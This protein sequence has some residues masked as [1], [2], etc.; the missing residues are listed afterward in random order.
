MVR[1]T[2]LAK[3]MT[4][5]GVS[6]PDFRVWRERNASFERMAAFSTTSYNISGDEE[7]ERV[8]GAVASIELIP[9]LG[10]LPAQGRSFAAEEGQFGG[11]RVVI[12]SDNLWQRRFGANARLGAQTIKL[13]GEVYQVVGVMPPGFEFPEKNVSLWVPLALP[14]KSPYA[15]RGNYWLSAIG[16]L[17]PG[18][19]AAQAQADLDRIHR[20][21]EQEVPD[22]IGWG[23]RI[24]SLREATVG[25]VR[26][27]L[28]TLFAA[29]GFVLLIACANVANL[30]LAR[31]AARQKEIAIRTALGAGRLRLVRQLFTESLLMGLFGGAGGL[32]LA[33]WGIDA[34][35]GLGPNFPRAGEIKID[36]QVL[37]FTLLLTFVTS[38]L[39]GLVPALQISK[40]GLHEALKESARGTVG[41]ARRSRVRGAL[42][43]AEIALSMVLLVGAG[44]MLGSLYQLQ[45]VDPGFKTENILTVQLSLPKTKYPND[46]PELTANFFS[47]L[48]ERVGATPGAKAVGYSTSLPFTESSWGKLLTIE[49]RP[50]PK[51]MEEM[52]NVQYSQTNVDYYQTLGIPLLKGR[53]F[54]RT[55]TA[56]TQPVALINETMARRYWPDGDPL[57]Q[58]IFLGP[59]EEMVPAG[60]LPPGYRFIRWTIVGVI[61]DQ[62]KRGLDQPVGPEVFTLQ[63]QGL[64]ND[65]PARNMYFAIHTSIPPTNLA[66]AVRHQVQ[67]LDKEQPIAAVATM[68][69]LISDSLAQSRFG[70]ITL[71]AFAA[72]A[73][74]LAMAGIYGVMS[75][76][77]TQ[78]THE[79]GIRMALGARQSDVL[80]DVLREGMRLALAG[81][82]CGLVLALALTRLLGSLLYGV[83]AADPVVYLS[84][85]VVLLLVALVACLVPARRATRVDPLV[86]LRYE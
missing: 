65:E 75:Y 40:S 23:A 55:D 22:T 48:A 43:I 73:L 45:R 19:S 53:L 81:G 52:I 84:V 46:K 71:G 11:H 34:L 4:D 37:I 70:A 21:L 80:R 49:G 20:Q 31:S 68:E 61:G 30:L 12:L 1:E 54:A 62:K 2:L 25:D 58:R 26:K 72:L 44:L 47:Q 24:V 74:T 28:L 15:T 77:V 85:G 39:F 3:G 7:P 86:A 13:N 63:E 57:G 69:E 8:V 29:V 76:T 14:D 42:V 9:L 83:S 78:R 5:A 79:I 17:K 16:R 36:Q 56:Q 82:V 66:S 35:V 33:V 10:V 64:T 51:S 59:P 38:L 67:E 27:I 60:I 18:V 50:A 6:M 32:A 41:S